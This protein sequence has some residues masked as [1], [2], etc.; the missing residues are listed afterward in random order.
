MRPRRQAFAKPAEGFNRRETQHD[1]ISLWPTHFSWNEHP[2]TAKFSLTITVLTIFILPAA[3]FAANDDET[4]EP[5][6]TSIIAPSS[7][8]PLPLYQSLRTKMDAL[9]AALGV[10]SGEPK[11]DVSQAAL[12]LRAEVRS[13]EDQLFS[14]LSAPQALQRE[15]AA[16]LMAFASD[17]KAA[18]RALCPL[19]SQDTDKNVR[20]AAA[21]ALT[22][23]PDAF[24]VDA[25]LGGLEDAEWI[26]RANC[27][28]ALGPIQD[29]RAVEP[30]FA[31]MG[32][33]RESQVRINA[34]TALA[35]IKTGVDAHRLSKML[36]DER[37][38]RV[39]LAIVGAIRVLE[40]ETGMPDIPDANQF[41]ERLMKLSDDMVEFERKLRDD[42]HDTTVQIEGDEIER[43]IDQLIEDIKKLAQD[44]P[45]SPPNDGSGS[46]S[47]RNPR[48][49]EGRAGAPK[50]EGGSEANNSKQMQPAGDSGGTGAKATPSVTGRH[51][52]WATL[53]A[54]DRDELFQIYR[55]EVPL[56]WRRRIEAY[57]FSVAAEEAR[58][59]AE[60]EKKPEPIAPIQE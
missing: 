50:P 59:Q 39:K 54:K 13:H 33:E 45:N 21:A 9:G 47:G 27:A 24:A 36:N 37:D 6:L 60:K 12:E 1:G 25:L 7:E 55:P 23:L 43:K 10:K 31:L 5:I 29:D 8:L 49:N 30:L 3:L 19:V 18:M 58:Q 4:P 48:P 14:A 17:K 52:R 57:F 51:E 44:N 35:R 22:L 28:K 40:G 34:V 32:G 46:S 38:E 26:V 16:R 41:G 42:R 53:P 11:V 15:L 20:A 56:K 2:M